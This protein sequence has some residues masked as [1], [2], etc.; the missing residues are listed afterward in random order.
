MKKSVLLF[1]IFFPLLWF[2]GCQSAPKGKQHSLRHLA[3][4]LAKAQTRLVRGTVAVF[5]FEVDKNFTDGYA[6]YVAE[7]LTHELVNQGSFSVVERS[8]LD[9]IL[10]EH[11]L[12][13]Q[14]ILDART[15]A[16]IGKLLSVEGVI[17]GSIHSEGN[18]V[19]VIARL[20][21]SESALI[22]RS[23][24][25]TYQDPEAITGGN[26]SS[27]GRISPLSGNE[28]TVTGGQLND[29][30]PASAELSQ[31]RLVPALNSL[32]ISALVTNKGKSAIRSSGLSL[33][34]YN[35]KGEQT[36]VVSLYSDRHIMPGETLPVSGFRKPAPRNLTRYKVFFQ[37]EKEDLFIYNTKFSSSQQ[38][39]YKDRY[40]GYKL[41]G[42]LKNQ[43]A[44]VVSYPK[45]IV[46]LLDAN[47]KFIGK[48]SGYTTIKKLQPG[49]SAPYEVTIYGYGLAGIPK[50][51][52]LH[53]AGLQAR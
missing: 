5:P 28:T 9:R 42:V 38:R 46:T 21:Q 8:R 49:Q 40:L 17:T 34:F 47:G 52:I 29:E 36:E 27:L 35:E 16:K 39:F 24:M 33:S 19:E 6:V 30:D 26:R 23:A 18:R 53:F 4:Q 31:L 44:F 14:G 43:N 15:A 1:V 2:S 12:G 3:Q 45:I 20:I 22:L 13:Q 7:H 37:P 32:Y 51:Y 41:E 25:V 11:Q 10:K 50:S 48:G